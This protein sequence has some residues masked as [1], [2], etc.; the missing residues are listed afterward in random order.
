VKRGHKRR[1]KVDWVY[2]ARKYT[3]AE[4]WDTGT[5]DPQNNE[6]VMS[7]TYYNPINLSA[8]SEGAT[9][10]VLYDSKEYINQKLA[11]DLNPLTGLPARFVVGPEARPDDHSRGALIHG[12]EIGIYMFIQGSSWVTTGAVHL[13]WRIIVA[14][15]DR[16][17]GRALLDPGY[18]MWQPSGGGGDETS[19]PAVFANG[20]L[21][22]YEERFFRP[23]RSDDTQMNYMIHR[24]FIPFKRRLDPS[25]GLFLYLE[26]HP[27]SNA[28]T[29]NNFVN[30]WCR[31]LVTDVS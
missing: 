27:N 26:L 7:G 30:L 1:Q 11:V 21:N 22:C 12:C 3:L 2:R 13:G 18:G 24:R 15:Q 6:T 10:Q 19:E 8:G 23:R 14:R 9:A 16:A 5:P 17:D 20:R 31:T 28:F 25:E 4:E 29:S